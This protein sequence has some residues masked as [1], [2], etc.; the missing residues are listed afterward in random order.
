MIIIKLTSAV[1]SHPAVYPNSSQIISFS[2]QAGGGCSIKIVGG[3]LAV[4]ESAET[5]M[6][7]IEEARAREIPAQDQ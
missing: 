5:V 3:V 1:G 7:R 4:V 2:D 6:K